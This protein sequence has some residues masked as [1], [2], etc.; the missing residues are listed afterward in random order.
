VT[1]R[2]GYLA[3][4]MHTM[5]RP[6]LGRLDI[7]QPR[8]R[9]LRDPDRDRALCGARINRHCAPPPEADKCLVCVDLATHGRYATR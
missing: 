2:S 6:T 3:T 4:A 7:G 5:P 9:H 1:A 8:L